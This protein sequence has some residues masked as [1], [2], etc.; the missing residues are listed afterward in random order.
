MFWKTVEI[1]SV[2]MTMSSVF[3]PSTP[4]H[5]VIWLRCFSRNFPLHVGM[6]ECSTPFVIRLNSSL[7]QLSVEYAHV[8]FN[9]YQCLLTHTVLFWEGR[10]RNRRSECC[11]EWTGFGARR[12]TGG[13]NNSLP[14]VSA[15]LLLCSVSNEVCSSFSVCVCTYLFMLRHNWD[16][17]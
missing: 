5:I 7:D 12:V 6:C 10:S 13:V 8:C 14:I 3:V 16:Q 11:S 1:E 2:A 15:W 17:A 4:I 9:W